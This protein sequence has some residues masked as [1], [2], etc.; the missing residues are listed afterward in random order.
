M[1]VKLS[2]TT[3]AYLQ[4]HVS[5]F[6]LLSYAFHSHL[7]NKP[8]F[9]LPPDRLSFSFLSPWIFLLVSVSFLFCFTLFSSLHMNTP[10]HL[11]SLLYLGF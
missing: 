8:D 11:Y 5:S 10:T 6:S 7:S 2:H 4:Q 3:L 1:F 9:H